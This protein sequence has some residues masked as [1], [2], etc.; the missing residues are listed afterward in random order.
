[1]FYIEESMAS[2]PMGAILSLK[3]RVYDHE[4]FGS[5]EEYMEHLAHSVWRFHG[6][7]LDIKG[8]SLEEKCLSC[9]EQLISKGLIIVN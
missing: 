1:M 9:M 6:V 2:D 3:E 7:G 4:R 5:L 8:S